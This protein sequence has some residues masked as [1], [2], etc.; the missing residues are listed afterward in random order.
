MMTLVDLTYQHTN[1][2]MLV[3][4]P[5]ITVRSV[6]ARLPTRG[7]VPLNPATTPSPAGSNRCSTILV[8]PESSS[9]TLGARSSVTTI[10]S[11]SPSVSPSFR[12]GCAPPVAWAAGGW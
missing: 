3:E 9:A 6:A 2:L 4:G 1:R 5:E 10:R 7:D 11:Y 12:Y 8:G